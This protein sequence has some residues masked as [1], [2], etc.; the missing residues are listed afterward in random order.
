MSVNST[1][2]EGPIYKVKFNEKEPVAI[3]KIPVTN[4]EENPIAPDPHLWMFQK[5]ANSIQQDYLRK[6]PMKFLI[7]DQIN[8]FVATEKIDLSDQMVKKWYTALANCNSQKSY[9]SLISVIEQDFI[10]KFS[11]WKPRLK[12]FIEMFKSNREDLFIQTPDSLLKLQNPIDQNE[13][14][15]CSVQFYKF[16]STSMEC[17]LNPFLCEI[18]ALLDVSPANQDIVKLYQKQRFEM[19]QK[20]DGL[21][22]KRRIDLYCLFNKIADEISREKNEFLI[23]YTKIMNGDLTNVYFPLIGSSN[24]VTQIIS[25]S[26]KSW[27]FVEKNRDIYDT[28]I[29][30]VEEIRT[31]IIEKSRS[32]KEKY[33]FLKNFFLYVKLG[34]LDKIKELPQTFQSTN[35]FKDLVFNEIK[36]FQ[37]QCKDPNETI[38]VQNFLKEHPSIKIMYI[39]GNLKEDF[40]SNILHV[41]Q[42]AIADA[43]EMCRQFSQHLLPHPPCHVRKVR[44]P[45]LNDQELQT[46]SQST[47][48]DSSE[49]IES[50][51][52]QSE[53]QPEI[54][55]LTPLKTLTQLKMVLT[56]QMESLVQSYTFVGYQEAIKNSIDQLEDLLTEV[57]RLVVL[58]PKQC[59]KQELL[60][61]I[62]N[63]INHGTLLTEQSLA[64]LV[65]KTTMCQTEKEL[66]DTMTHQLPL[67]LNSC[68]LGTFPLKEKTRK[69][70]S[71]TNLGE[72][73]SR[74]LVSLVENRPSFSMISVKDLL[75]SVYSWS[76]SED[77]QIQKQLVQSIVD[78]LAN[79][80]M[81]N[82]DIQFHIQTSDREKGK[83]LIK[84]HKKADKMIRHLKRLLLQDVEN[85]QVVSSSPIQHK[86]SDKLANIGIQ[87]T[88]FLSQ[89]DLPLMVQR[90]FENLQNNLLSR[91][92][93]ELQFQ[94]DLQPRELRLHYCHTLLLGQYM[95]EDFLYQLIYKKGI[96]VNHQEIDHNLVKL[97][98]LLGYNLKDFDAGVQRFL[99]S[100]KE[101]RTLMRYRYG[102]H[103]N[104][105]V[106]KNIHNV[107]HLS[108]TQVFEEAV[109]DGFQIVAKKGEIESMLKNV[110]KHV[111]ALHTLICTLSKDYFEEK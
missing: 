28:Y 70:I 64:A 110:E 97:F 20:A 47:Q 44:T 25:S 43:I 49:E 82:Q 67:L 78:Y 19:I 17:V 77:Q 56:K 87:L 85:M 40:Y 66:K 2:Y 83:E 71:Q 36:R 46:V 74:D 30:K 31:W 105:E 84:E 65:R 51:T 33:F 86:Y 42:Y 39:N 14:A 35:K 92:N 1:K 107:S 22:T 60:C 100:S 53:Q 76:I 11:N 90:G 73:L 29:P 62:V 80:L 13:L 109:H 111:T 15:R 61:S 89:N 7:Q 10:P 59:S 24:E 99:K 55:D 48:N 103:K 108:Q 37:E 52:A 106:L 96:E 81:V 4:S 93:V 16:L 3:K 95:A 32:L 101:V 98:E 8:G 88:T 69:M 68:N 5:Y 27:S 104:G 79:I 12:G 6:I 9:A 94:N 23:F 54:K 63:I 50:T 38:K 26:T 21:S 18:M 34:N 45:Y 91:L 57:A 75:A 41:N 58:L 102:V 72:I